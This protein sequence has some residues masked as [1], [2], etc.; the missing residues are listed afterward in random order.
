M[1][2]F[3]YEALPGRVIFG[4]GALA[5]LAEELERLGARRVLMIAGRSERPIAERVQAGLGGRAVGVFGDVRAHVPVA[6]AGAARRAAQELHA[7]CLVC[8]G[9]GSATGLA[10]AVAL[11]SG[12]PICAVPTTYAGS[13]VTPVYGTTSGE[14]KQTGRDLRVLP[15]VVIYDPAL[16]VSLPP[17]VTGPSGMNAIAHCVEA[18]YAEAANPVTSLCAEEGIRVLARSLPPL[19]QAPGDLD[20]RSD[21]LYGAYLAGSAL[22][23]AGVAIH[24]RICHVLGGS[25]GLPHGDL[26]A[27]V[28]PHAVAFNAPAAPAAIGR[29]ARALGVDEPAGGLFD[30]AVR[31]QAPTSLQYLGLARGDLDKAIP[32]IVRRPPPNPRPVDEPGIRAL[33]ED[34]YLGRRPGP[35]AGSAGGCG[36]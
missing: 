34:A 5:R 33:L 18:L 13:E 22:A 6:T 28:L 21:A 1:E 4:V 2:P 24:H 19:V 27:V 26:N 3:T 32:M 9:G 36:P 17:S 10:K 15:K 7:D 30:L 14:G 25:F 35:L 31:L 29:I 12:L 11:A 23:V 20:A 16:T 8:L